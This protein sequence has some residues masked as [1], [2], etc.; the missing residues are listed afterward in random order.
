MIEAVLFDLDDT[1]L[2]NNVEAFLRRYLPLLAAYARELIEP[3]KFLADLLASTRAMI[4]N[5][6]LAATN[7]EVFWAD[8]NRRT[9]LEQ[10][11]AEPIFDRF[12]REHFPQLQSVT[13]PRAAAAP[14]VRACLER[15]LKVAIATNPL[16]PRLA[17]EHRLA[18]AGLPVSEFDFALVT[19]YENMHATKPHLAY[20]REILDIIGVKPERALMVGDEWTNDIAPAAQLGLYTYWTPVGA[21]APPDGATALNGQGTLE[22]LHEWLAAGWLL[23]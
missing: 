21:A 16:F 15:G 20:Y 3:E 14:L 11:S 8:F 10:L 4:E 19:S 9:G 12:Y 1:L 6:N 17:I 5:T 23:E 13:R 22:E 7:R 18:W 2:E